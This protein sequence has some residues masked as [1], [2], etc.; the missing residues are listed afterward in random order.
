[1]NVQKLTSV[2]ISKTGTIG[3]YMIRVYVQRYGRRP[4]DGS[5]LQRGYVARGAPAGAPLV[6]ALLELEA[7][8]HALR[9]PQRLHKHDEPAGSLVEAV[10]GARLREGVAFGRRREQALDDVRQG[11]PAAAAAVAVREDTLRLDEHRDV[12]VVVEDLDALQERVWGVLLPAQ[13]LQRT[14][15]DCNAL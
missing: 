10:P 6:N 7:A 12:A 15:C 11:L 9:R 14:R 5:S 13:D 8:L 3:T 1:M 2:Q 4:R